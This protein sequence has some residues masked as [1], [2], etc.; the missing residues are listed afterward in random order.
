MPIITGT[1]EAESE[2][3]LGK[4]SETLSQKHNTNQSVGCVAQVVEW[5]P[6]ICKTLGSSLSTI[7]NQSKNL[8]RS[9]LVNPK[10][11]LGV[12]WSDFEFSIDHSLNIHS[13]TRQ[14]FHELVHHE[15]SSEAEETQTTHCFY[16]S[17]YLLLPLWF[18]SIFNSSL[19]PLS[20]L[21]FPHFW[22]SKRSW[23]CCQQL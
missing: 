10:H 13:L 3:S 19:F 12:I 1:Q 23:S 20:S 8:F 2:D 16:L 14:R 22:G 9:L 17:Q 18:L 11:G 7:I 5:L 4:V 15:E 6:S 21:S